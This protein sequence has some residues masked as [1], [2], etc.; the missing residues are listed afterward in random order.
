MF[1]LLKKIIKMF[2]KKEFNYVLLI[3]GS[4]TGLYFLR[5]CT[6]IDINI[7][8]DELGTFAGM[9]ACGGLNW[10]EVIAYT[11]Y[12]GYGFYWIYAFIFYLIDNPYI[13]Y[14]LIYFLNAV[15]I[16]CTGILIW[17]LQTKLLK[18]PANSCTFLITILCGTIY[19]V[20]NYSYITN[21]VATYAVYWIGV[22]FLISSICTEEN[23][24]RKQI[25]FAICLCYSLT[26]HEKMIVLWISMAFVLIIWKLFCGTSLIKNK[27][28]YICLLVGYILA[29]VSK[30]L[31]I[32]YFWP[33]DVR[34]GEELANTSVIY[35]DI[36]WFF[37]DLRGIRA[38]FDVI[39]SNLLKTGIMT[40]GLSFLGIGLFIVLFVSF[41]KRIIMNGKLNSNEKLT[42]I[43]Q[44]ISIFPIMIII[45]GLA[46][47]WGKSI[48][49]SI[50][51]TGEFGKNVRAFSYIRY[52]IIF[53]GPMLISVYYY[54]F[55][56]VGSKKV[57]YITGLFISIFCYIYFCLIIM[58]YLGTNGISILSSIE[59]G[60]NPVLNLGI[61]FLAL[62][63]LPILF[64]GIINKKIRTIFVS[65][66]TICIVSL[67]LPDSVTWPILKY[68]LCDATMIW[69]E[70]NINAENRD[71]LYVLDDYSNYQFAFNRYSMHVIN[72]N[73]TKAII[74]SHKSKDMWAESYMEDFQR[75][76]IMKC[77]E[78][79]LDD[80]EYIFYLNE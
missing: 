9:A 58:P 11:R 2:Q 40:G 13:I 54:I 7:S 53:V 20:V 23:S 68:S 56:K 50:Y 26:V 34:L 14:I 32:D 39:I 76:V 16:G 12:Y 80:N 33:A 67:N 4:T 66:S 24:V 51:F 65:L 43:L 46:V 79:Q 35:G 27:S 48:Y 21:D 45:V 17:R 5:I 8:M 36:T 52:Y 42:L 75:E 70:D 74:F 6:I 3:F 19:P 57:F 28:L 61:S 25:Y 37:S 30:Q 10:N 31:V 22:Y 78:I 15:I 62:F 71:L 64:I 55:Y 41:T 49:E 18:L 72:G 38:I 59:I 47:E 1:Y 73:E 63:I 60:H 29:R 44:L 77:Q 69:I